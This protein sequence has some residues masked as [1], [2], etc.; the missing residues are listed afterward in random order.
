MRCLL[1]FLIATLCGCSLLRSRYA[2]DDPEYASK[3]ADG[4]KRWDLVGKAKQALDARHT[5]GLG[6]LYASGGAQVRPDSG[7][8][9][10]G[11]ELGAEGYATSWLTGRAALS[12]YYGDD[13]GFLGLEVGARLQTP[14]RVAPFVGV[15]TFQGASRGVELADHDGLDNDDDWWI[16]EPGE[17]RS[18][19]D[20]FLSVVYPEVGAHVWI[21]GNWRVTTYGRY[22]IT[23]EGRDSDDWLVGLQVTRFG[24]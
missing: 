4:A 7:N 3:Y 20:R 24:R 23:S 6:G 18:T 2:M 16:D 19:V 12:G 13:E 9:M 8:A 21:D 10:F 14:T 22:F 1:V 17:D 15:G 5:Q 11:G